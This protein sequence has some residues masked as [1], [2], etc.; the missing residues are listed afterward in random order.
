MKKIYL[1]I[2]LCLV[3]SKALPQISAIDV[4][5]G[6]AQ[7]NV[8]DVIIVF[9]MHFDIGYTGWAEGVL[10]KYT[11]EMLENTLRQIDETYD[12]PK[13]E[14]FIW[15][16]P[17][18]PLKYIIENCPEKQKASLRKAL[19]SG[20]IT[21]HGLP[22]TYETEASDIE[23]LVRGLS[24]SDQIRKEAG[25]E[26]ARDAK[27]TD[28]PSHSHFLPTLLKNA[29]IDFLH[30]GCNAGSTSP[31]IPTL[32]WWKG[33]DDKKIL[34]MNWAEYYGSGVLPPKNWPYK[35]WL[36]VIHTHENT[37]AP[38][39][40]EVARILKEAKEKMPQARIRIGELKDF[41]DCLMKENSQIPTIEGDMPDTWIHGF[42]SNPRATALS[43][44]MH[45]LTYATEA[46]TTMLQEWGIKQVE[47]RTHFDKAIENQ[48]LY[49]EHTFGIAISH[50]NQSGWSYDDMFLLN[51][52]LGLYD[53]AEATWKEKQSRIEAAE[54][55]VKPILSNSIHTLADHIDVDGK[56]IVVYNPDI[57]ERT[58]R[59]QL[60]L[61][62]YMRNFNVNRLRDTQ[63]G[64][65]VDVYTDNN[66][67][68]FTAK[69]VPALGYKT[70]EI[71]SDTGDSKPVSVGRTEN[72]ENTIENEYFIARIDPGKGV[73]SSLYDKLRKK[74]LV[75][76]HA[77]RGFCEYFEEIYGQDDM[78]RYCRAYVKKGQEGWASPEMSRPRGVP[79]KE[80]IEQRGRV[81]RMQYEFMSNGARISV[82]GITES[83][84]P[85]KYIISYSLYAGLP[86]LEVTLGINAKNPDAKAQAGWLA[87][88]FN[89]QKPSYKALRLGG[90]VEP[91]K[92][93][94]NYT[95]HYY[96]Y[97]NSSITLLDNDRSGVAVDT[98]DAPGISMDSTGLFRFGKH[99][100]P[101]TSLLYV[102]LYNTQWGTNFTEWV[103]G[104]FHATVRI[105][106]FDQYNPEKSLVTP[107]EESRTPLFA[108]YS[109]KPNGELP[110][111]Y[112]G[113]KLDRKGIYMTALQKNEDD[114]LLRLW[115]QAGMGGEVTITLPESF[116]YKKAMLCNLRNVK[117]GKEIKITGQKL[118]LSIDAN[119][120]AT[121][122][123]TAQ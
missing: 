3:Y 74:E 111:Y 63:T 119:A 120:P 68:S 17:A 41:Y 14:Q 24:Y 93:F 49:D 9:K 57:W 90:I 86:Y 53:Y 73:V 79:N 36:A 108:A 21:P 28:V 39:K 16:V 47:H 94:I 106:S 50:G 80:T 32:C 8:T 102:N 55:I 98:P 83:A 54:R 4:N 66:L 65:P 109:D 48:F 35:T 2:L 15:T 67:V 30:I 23:T 13:E 22:G 99:F 76:Q 19:K 42:S 62:V 78:D 37:G 52:S 27:L 56:R 115:E 110:A 84:N 113:L 123:L 26:L 104:A 43:R 72:R 61:G 64:E 18:W 105:R 112:E 46:L 38:T 10:Q 33:V 5:R 88:P 114:L 81:E 45:R 101:K 96:Y 116:R 118:R 100:E 40:E 51:K 1:L 95:N 25:R 91:G 77:D 103:E 107:S 6:S 7:N 117:L 92:D 29:G 34:L 59:V 70:Y 71:I 87:F 121:L 60:F 75:D 85:Q 122:L 12:L 69:N 97:L 11:G 44:E 89:I 20:R 82:F 31:E 58:D